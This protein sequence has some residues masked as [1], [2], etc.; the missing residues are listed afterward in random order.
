MKFRIDKNL[1]SEFPDLSIGLLLVENIDNTKAK[2]D[3]YQLL[4]QIIEENAV[5]YRDLTLN[6]IENIS[7]WN[8]AFTKIG[9]NSN[10]IYPS[11][12][13]LIKRVIEHNEIPNV[14]PLVNIY[15]Y[16]SIK[17]A[18]PL[19]GHNLDAIDGDITVGQNT[20]KLKFS[21]IGKST[22]EDVPENEI[23][24]FDNKDILTRNWVWRQSDK[25]KTMENTQNILIPIDNIGNISSQELSK[26]I[27]E[28]K[29]IIEKYLGTEKSIYK[30]GKVSLKNNEVDLDKLETIKNHL[31]IRFEAKPVKT[32][33]E[34]IDTLLDRATEEILPS[35]QFLEK[36]LYSGRRLNVYQGFD[37]TA[38][39]LHIGHT[40]GM[41]KLRFFQRLGH[42][43]IFLIGDFTARIGDPTDKSA[44][45]VKLTKQK[46]KENLKK[47]KEQ[48]SKLLDFDN[49]ENP[50]QV[51]FN[52]DWLEKLDF[53]DIL[54]ITSEFTVQQMIK[55]DMFKRR[56]DEDRPIYLNEFMYP[57]MQAYDSVVMN[58][59]VEV[60][61]NDQMF[62]MICGRDLTIRLRNKE[63]AVLPNKLL[64]DPSGKKMGKSEG[65]MIMLSD[66]AN[67]MY[68]KVMTFT[69][70]MICPAFEILT[71]I[72]MSEIKQM[73][74]DMD[75]GKVNPMQ[76]KKK[77]AFIITSEHKGD[78]EAKK[79]QEYFENIFQKKDTSTEVA[80]ETIISKE[81]NISILDLLS[82]VTAITPSNSEA[83]RLISQ[84]AVRVEGKTVTDKQ[85]IIKITEKGIELRVGK[86]IKRIKYKTH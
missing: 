11:H 57:V 34:I 70:G 5:R 76:L 22:Q 56:I 44:A 15:N 49:K 77:L 30:F 58:I 33:K 45:R 48:A 72:P 67:D 39:T 1:L 18:L 14:N 16:I 59:D 54:E 38:D 3:T 73:Q 7:S 28:L 43:V 64:V 47:Y 80:I 74:K 68:G 12:K 9:I 40:V 81:K 86:K 71:D 24:Y 41:R 85:T 25:S 79:A 75:K 35:R 21:P 29:S 50:I 65:N 23:A 62:N 10:E 46:V 84:K 42:N 8:N 32:D 66:N 26:I 4:W 27:L 53:G 13:A 55:R 31:P 83:K 61:G 63:K 19:G 37:P 51:M 82:K 69:D 36:L 17:Y 20:G 6:A 2:N 52:A 60:G 78:N